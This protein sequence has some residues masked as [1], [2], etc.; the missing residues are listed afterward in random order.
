MSDEV[1]I[2]IIKT[3]R[4]LIIGGACLLFFWILIRITDKSVAST[5]R[6]TVGE[7]GE[8]I[9][10]KYGLR[11]LNALGGIVLLVCTLFLFFGGLSHLV[12]PDIGQAAHTDLGTLGIYLGVLYGFIFYF[13]LSLMACR[14]GN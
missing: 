13:S 1:I 14:H 12:L 8:L 9:K 5:I 4:P 11:G 3:V 6:D 7:F 2:E 10:G